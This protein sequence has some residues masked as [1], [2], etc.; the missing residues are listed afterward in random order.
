MLPYYV[1]TN[2]EFYNRIAQEL[3]EESGKAKTKE[4]YENMLSAFCRKWMK[5]LTDRNVM[6]YFWESGTIEPEMIEEINQWY[7]NHAGKFQSAFL[8][9]GLIPGNKYTLVYLND[10]GFPVAHKITFVTMY[11]CQYA[12]YTDA[13]RIQYKMYRRRGVFES[14]FH[15]QSIVVYSGWI[16]LPENFGSEIV[17]KSDDVTVTKS[18]YSCFDSRYMDDA[19][20][21]LPEPLMVWKNY[22]T[23]VNGRIYA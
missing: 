19:L 8:N 10:W 2:T 11:P 5:D 15:E 14:V 6:Q 17:R 13:M 16:D 20:S 3:Y 1:S 9:A 12:Q 4:A 21:V 22:R 18:K 7:I 23:G